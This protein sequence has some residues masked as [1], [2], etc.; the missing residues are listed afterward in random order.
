[1]RR[2]SLL[3]AMF[4]IAVDDTGIEATFSCVADEFLSFTGEE[5]SDPVMI[6][7][8]FTATR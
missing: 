2:P 1:M 5:P 7:G 4:V 3:P 6:E 8:S